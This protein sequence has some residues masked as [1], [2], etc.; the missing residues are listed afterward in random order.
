MASIERTA[1]P[2]LK[3]NIS[4]KELINYYNLLLPEIEHAY[5]FLKNKDFVIRVFLHVP[6]KST[7]KKLK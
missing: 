7:N 5:S 6:S 4:Q 3:I 2:K 1:Y